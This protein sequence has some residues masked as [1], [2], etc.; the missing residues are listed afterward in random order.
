MR[1]C[2]GDAA[3]AGSKITLPQYYSPLPIARGARVVN[4]S[5]A[6]HGRPAGCT[7]AAGYH[8]LH[9]SLLTASLYLMQIQRLDVKG[10]ARS[11]WLNVLPTVASGYA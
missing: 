9:G 10:F 5:A 7:G 1:S 11:C 6:A 2:R 4:H 8:K 3:I